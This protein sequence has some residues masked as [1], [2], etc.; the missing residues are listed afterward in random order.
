[1]AEAVTAGASVS[2]DAPAR[3]RAGDQPAADQLRT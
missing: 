2:T 3:I 1:M